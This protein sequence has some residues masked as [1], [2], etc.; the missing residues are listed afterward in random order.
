MV[1]RVAWNLI[2]DTPSYYWQYACPLPSIEFGGSL[3]PVGAGE[4]DVIC[5]VQ[6]RPSRENGAAL[7]LWTIRD[8]I[9]LIAGGFLTSEDFVTV[10]HGQPGHCPRYIHRREMPAIAQNEQDLNR[11]ST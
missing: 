3:V 6:W 4:R 2:I 7:N 5:E 9:A 1:F 10:E 11:I 8:G